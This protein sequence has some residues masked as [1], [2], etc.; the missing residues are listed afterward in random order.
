[1]WS[2]LRDGLRAGHPF[3]RRMPDAAA[4]GRSGSGRAVARTTARSPTIPRRPHAQARRALGARLPYGI[5][6]R[7]LSLLGHCRGTRP[8]AGHVTGKVGGPPIRFHPHTCRGGILR[9]R[10][11]LV[12]SSGGSLHS[13]PWTQGRQPRAERKRHVVGSSATRS[14]PWPPTRGRPAAVRPDRL[15]EAQRDPAH[16]RPGLTASGSLVPALPTGYIAVSADGCCL[17]SGPGGRL[18]VIC[19]RGGR[20]DR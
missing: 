13:L 11:H 12:R 3:G 16:R 7:L 19:R 5:T 6:G 18:Q 1:M 14:W 15:A 4:Q 2:K 10:V 17:P 8:V 9:R 20:S